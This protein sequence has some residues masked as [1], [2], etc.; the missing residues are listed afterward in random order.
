MLRASLYFHQLYSGFKRR[1]IITS[2]LGFAV[3]SAGAKY[4]IAERELLMITSDFC[5]YCM[6]WERD[7]GQIYNKS[8]YASVLP[9]T[10]IEYGTSFPKDIQL[11]S[12]IK[13]TPTFIILDDRNEIDRIIGYS[14]AEMFWWQISEYA[15][16]PE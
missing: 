8:P 15:E 12:D 1:L 2:L 4:V 11:A 9:L 10:K 16:L 7:I 6:A 3:L 5:P 13:G 14:D